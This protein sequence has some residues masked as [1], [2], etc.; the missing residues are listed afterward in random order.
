[1][2]G[3]EDRQRGV[4][5]YRREARLSLICVVARQR[6]C[7]LQPEMPEAVSQLDGFLLDAVRE[8]SEYMCESGRFRP[9]GVRS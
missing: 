1:M 9:K 6:V 5:T 2:R 4:A 7:A 3:D 8:Q